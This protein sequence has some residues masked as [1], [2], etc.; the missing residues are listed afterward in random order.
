[1]IICMGKYRVNH[2]E[3][4]GFTFLMV[5]EFFQHGCGTVGNGEW[6]SLKSQRKLIFILALVPTTLDTSLKIGW[7]M[8]CF[9][10]FQ[11]FF[12]PHSPSQEP[13]RGK[14]GRVHLS[15]WT[16]CSGDLGSCRRLKLSTSAV[17][18]SL[19]AYSRSHSHMSRSLSNLCRLLWIR[20][21]RTERSNNQASMTQAAIGF[22]RAKCFN[23]HPIPSPHHHS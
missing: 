22:D 23:P 8:H 1:M 21:L 3:E 12:L 2:S 5:Q 6:G 14:P 7:L 15:Q 20:T 19:S 4:H 10:L 16:I 18:R 13:Q 11:A 9:P 17:S